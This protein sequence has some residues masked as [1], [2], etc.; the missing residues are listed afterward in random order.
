ARRSRPP[1]TGP[2]DAAASTVTRR[3]TGR[4]IPRAKSSFASRQEHL[5][6]TTRMTM[7]AA[8]LLIAAGVAA[9]DASNAVA[10][11]QDVPKASAAAIPDIPLVNQIDFGVRGT[12]FSS[13]S[14]EARFQRYRDVRNGGTLDR[15]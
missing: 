11:Q 9:Q 2:W 12:G 8:L 3:S 4:T 1:A 13:G 6:R 14:D 7:V 5:M 10:T 15:L